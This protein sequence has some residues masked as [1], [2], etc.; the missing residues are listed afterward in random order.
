M[1]TKNIKL[2]CKKES[3]KLSLG[4]VKRII[5]KYFIAT[6]KS[7]NDTRLSTVYWKVADKKLHPGIS[8]NIKGSYKLYNPNSIRW[9]LFAVKIGNSR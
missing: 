4:N 9:S 2:N 1:S 7:K 3:E 6:K 8:W 5:K